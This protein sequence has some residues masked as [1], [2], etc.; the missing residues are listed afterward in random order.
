MRFKGW[1]RLGK[2]GSL[3]TLT[4]AL[5]T[6]AG[7]AQVVAPPHP[8]SYRPQVRYVV[9]GSRLSRLE[10]FFA[11]T[12]SLK[13]HG[14]KK[15]DGSDE[16]AEDPAATVLPGTVSARGTLMAYW[17]NRTCVRVLLMPAGY[18]IPDGDQPVKIQI[19]LDS[20]RELH[21]QRLLA[22]QAKVLLAAQGFREAVGYDNRGHTLLQ[23][24]IPAASLSRLLD[25]LR[26]QTGWLAP[27]LPLRRCPS[28]FIQR[29][30]FDSSK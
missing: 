12:K 6:Q 29:G 1:R 3:W 28:R 24:T 18:Q 9:G 13:S 27:R 19:E 30:R 4:L 2:H 10:Q 25:D 16:L 7:Q 23:G 20:G 15:A 11:M 8:A 21:R 17:A 26:L 22:D 5:G 14:F